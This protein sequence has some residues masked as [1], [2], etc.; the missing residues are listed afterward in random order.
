MK[1]GDWV[2]LGDV[3]LEQACLGDRHSLR[4]P[5]EWDKCGFVEELAT[6]HD[7][8]WVRISGRNDFMRMGLWRLKEIVYGLGYDPRHP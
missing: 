1:V 2:R 4:D 8:E 6:W 3:E 7:G 5:T